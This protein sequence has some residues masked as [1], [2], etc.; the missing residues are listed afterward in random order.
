MKRIRVSDSR[1]GYLYPNLESMEENSTTESNYTPDNTEAET[2]TLDDPTD[3]DTAS[4]SDHYLRVKPEF[5]KK[6]YFS[7]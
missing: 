5:K 2:A 6:T 4:E 7:L 1:P 3:A